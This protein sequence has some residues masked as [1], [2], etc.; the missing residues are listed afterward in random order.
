[1]PTKSNTK[2]AYA[3]ERIAKLEAQ[4]AQY[5]TP[6]KRAIA[7]ALLALARAGKPIPAH[8][9]LSIKHGTPEWK[10]FRHC[11]AILTSQTH[12]PESEPKVVQ[13]ARKVAAAA[14][15]ARVTRTKAHTSAKSPVLVF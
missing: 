10:A 11:R 14:P 8:T 12:A 13:Q 15:K 6:S 1:M 2:V 3:P 7:Q 9:A 4:A 5:L